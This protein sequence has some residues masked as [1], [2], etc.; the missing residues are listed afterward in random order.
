MI[1]SQVPNVLQIYSD[2]TWESSIV[3]MDILISVADCTPQ[4]VVQTPGSQDDW[5]VPIISAFGMNR[6]KIPGAQ[7]RPKVYL[8]NP[9]QLIYQCHRIPR[10]CLFCDNRSLPRTFGREAPFVVSCMDAQIPSDGE[11]KGQTEVSN[12]QSQAG[13][14]PSPHC[15]EA[16]YA[17]RMQIVAASHLKALPPAVSLRS[18]APFLKLNIFATTVYSSPI[19]EALSYSSGAW[20]VETMTLEGLFDVFELP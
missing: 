12:Q 15:L 14:S 18:I 10:K 2:L 19:I 13:P 20:H 17:D 1:A 6:L 3:S 8:G 7:R 9:P 4:K 11:I 16:H 5:I